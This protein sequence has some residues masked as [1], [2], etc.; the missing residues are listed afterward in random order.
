[1]KLGFLNLVFFIAL[2]FILLS[3]IPKPCYQ[4]YFLYHSRILQFHSKQVFKLYLKAFQ[5]GLLS[6]SLYY[7]LLLIYYQLLL[8]DFQV[9]IINLFEFLIRLKFIKLFHRIIILIDRSAI[10]CLKLL[11]QESET[12]YQGR[13]S[14]FQLISQT[15]LFL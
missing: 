6:I 14:L 15:L 10:L 11:F 12:G 5:S 3:Q 7:L 1:M 9:M 4:C 8:N 13:V 2:T